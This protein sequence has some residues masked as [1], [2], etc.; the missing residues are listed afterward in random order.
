MKIYTKTGDRGETSLIGGQRVP[1]YHLRLEAY[2]TVDELTAF[3]GLLRDYSTDSHTNMSLLEIQ[4]KL[5]VCAAILASDC[6][7]CEI[8]LPEIKNENILFLEQ[9]I[10]A[11]ESNLPQLSSFILSGGHPL[12]SYCHVARTVCRRAE[13]LIIKLAEE[14]KVPNEVLQYVNRLSDYFFVLSRKFSADLKVIEQQ[15]QP[16][17]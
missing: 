13:R 15:W 8:K 14:T 10:D 12:V 11:M 16:K 5:M 7:N 6:E 1:K 3:T 17:L 2:G 9:E 4:D